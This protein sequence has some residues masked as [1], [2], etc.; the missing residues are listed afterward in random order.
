MA[1]LLDQT[2]GDAY[3]LG[4]SGATPETIALHVDLPRIANLRE[5]AK[6]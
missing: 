3:I 5:F 4:G 6:R 2:R 1:C